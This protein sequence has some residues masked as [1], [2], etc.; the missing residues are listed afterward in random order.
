VNN[1]FVVNDISTR[2]HRRPLTWTNI[3]GGAMC[4]ASIK[5]SSFGSNPE[6]LKSEGLNAVDQLVGSFGR[7]YPT[8]SRILSCLAMPDPSLVPRPEVPETWAELVRMLRQ[9]LGLSRPDFAALIGV[10]IET[11]SSWEYRGVVPNFVMQDLIV[12]MWQNVDLLRKEL[13]GQLAQYV[14]QAQLAGLDSKSHGN[15]EIWKFA[16]GTGIGVGAMALLFNAVNH[17]RL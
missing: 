15:S 13:D 2:E 12:R 4:A 3:P 11:L 6:R 10:S 16:L 5:H 1:S 14:P 7:L 17:P 8:G 9:R